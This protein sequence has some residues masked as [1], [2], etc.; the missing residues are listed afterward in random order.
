MSKASG[1]QHLLSIFKRQ[2]RTVCVTEGFSGAKIYGH[3][4]YAPSQAGYQLRLGVFPFLI[5]QTS[6]C[7]RFPAVSLI[8]LPNIETYRLVVWHGKISS[9]VFKG[10]DCEYYWPC[11]S[12]ISFY[13]RF[14]LYAFQENT[15]RSPLCSPLFPIFS[16][17]DAFNFS[18]HSTEVV[19]IS[20]TD[21]NTNFI[22]SHIRKSE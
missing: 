17:T 14:K 10:R 6:Q 12:C 2:H 11:L 20:H 8:D 22:H 13:F 9:E 4:E 19:C 1:N 7:E 18:E 15:G 21:R 16:W 3:I 5:M